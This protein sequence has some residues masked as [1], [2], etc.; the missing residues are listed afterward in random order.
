MLTCQ[1]LTRS[2]LHL[3]VYLYDDVTS[4]SVSFYKITVQAKGLVE[5]TEQ[6]FSRLCL[7]I[8][9]HITEHEWWALCPLGL[10]SC[11]ILHI[12]IYSTKEMLKLINFISL[13]DRKDCNLENVL[14]VPP[15]LALFI[16]Y[17]SLPLH[18]LFAV[19]LNW[20]CSQTSIA[21]YC[22]YCTIVLFF[23]CSMQWVFWGS[24]HKIPYDKKLYFW[25]YFKI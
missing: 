14:S 16:F 10:R 9:L 12:H 7:E 6:S 22:I 21:D 15:A 5:F 13:C 17:F 20:V 24:G 3:Y 1:T 11:L 19:R 18:S 8:G 4:W 2:E 25:M 23:L